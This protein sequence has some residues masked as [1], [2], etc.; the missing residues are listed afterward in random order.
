MVLWLL[1][2]IKLGYRI[3]RSLHSSGHSTLNL[4]K[5]KKTISWYPNSSLIFSELAHHQW[6][7][8]QAVCWKQGAMITCS[9]AKIQIEIQWPTYYICGLPR[10]WNQSAMATSPHTQIRISHFVNPCTIYGS[11]PKLYIGGKPLRSR[12]LV[13]NFESESV[14]MATTRRNDYYGSW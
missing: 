10:C 5:Q 14:S 7:A 9:D 6:I 3:D 4:W 2:E 11:S 13:P 1:V 8:S 12:F